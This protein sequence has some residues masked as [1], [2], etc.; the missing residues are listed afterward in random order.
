MIYFFLAGVAA[1][2]LAK[3]TRSWGAYALTPLAAIFVSAGSVLI[4]S[5]RRTECVGR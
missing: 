2:L 4:I 3:S 1:Y 5:S